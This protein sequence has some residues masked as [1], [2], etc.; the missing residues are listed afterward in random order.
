MAPVQLLWV[1]MTTAVI[2]GMPLAF[3]AGRTDIMGLSPRNPGAPLLSNVYIIRTFAVGAMLLMGAFSVFSLELEMSG[4]LAVA[5]TAAANCLV[6]MEAFYLFNCRQLTLRERSEATGT[7]PFLWVGIAITL[8]LQ[9]MFVYAP[10]MQKLFHTAPVSPVSWLI[11]VGFGVV[12]AVLVEIEKRIRRALR[13]ED[14]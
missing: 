6:L 7:N 2:L 12:L 3:E 1:N 4:D 14:F 13:Q 9:V 10:F 11:T 8:G 5:R